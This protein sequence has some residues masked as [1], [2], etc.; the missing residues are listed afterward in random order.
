MDCDTAEAPASHR[1][2]HARRA[3]RIFLAEDNPVVQHTF[4]DALQDI[5]AQVVG[6]AESEAGAT[7]WLQAHPRDW[8]VAVVDLFLARGTGV[9]V[10]R[11]VADRTRQQ[12]V[13]VVTNYI[14][15]ELRSQCFALGAN[16]VFDKGAQQRE[17]MS[18][19]R[20]L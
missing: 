8:D 13:L 12:K 15:A 2:A 20:L 5:G 10:L 3:L 18:L 17:L 11:G 4:A 14:T 16:G 1:A 19:L 6:R 7:Q 9:G